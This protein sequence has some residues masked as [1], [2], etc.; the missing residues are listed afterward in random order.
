MSKTQT[1]GREDLVVED[2][3][4]MFK[5]FAG[6]ASTFNPVG[7]RNFS[8]VIDEDLAK[9]LSTDGWN[10]KT[11]VSKDDPDAVPTYHLP[12]AVAYEHKPPMVKI[13]TSRGQ[14]MLD[15]SMVNMLDQAEITNLD[16]IVTPYHWETPDGK[17]GVKA[18]LKALYATIEEDPLQKKYSQYDADADEDLPF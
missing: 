4:I 5:N 1:Y 14:T 3:Q 7:C 18:Y 15:E 13:I 10:V 11:Y 9:K 8:L 6:R 12:V 17:S 2:A 16:M